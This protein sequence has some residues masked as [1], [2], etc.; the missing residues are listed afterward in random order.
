MIRGDDSVLIQDVRRSGL[1]RRH[2]SSRRL[3]E[4]K[5]SNAITGERHHGKQ[6]NEKVISHSGPAV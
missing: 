3:R 2:G 6:S 4:C 5:E 1:L